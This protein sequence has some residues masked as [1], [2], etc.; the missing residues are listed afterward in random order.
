MKTSSWEFVTQTDQTKPPITQK[1]KETTFATH[2]FSHP[3]S[4]RRST[5]S[6][7]SP[8]WSVIG[9]GRPFSPTVSY[10]IGIS[11]SLVSS[12]LHYDPHTSFR[13]MAQRGLTLI[14]RINNPHSATRIFHC[15]ST[16]LV[17]ILFGSLW[18]TPFC[19]S[20]RFPNW[21]SWTD[22]GDSRLDGVNP[23]PQLQGISSRGQLDGFY[24]SFRCGGCLHCRSLHRLVSIKKGRDGVGSEWRRCRICRFNRGHPIG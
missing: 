14:F 21:T 20:R 17:F 10:S 7:C 16:F 3:I 13:L 8:R 19:H 22:F 5:G 23:I 11:L 24:C 9:R 6:R 1:F 18:T 12:H 15:C 2:I 4:Q